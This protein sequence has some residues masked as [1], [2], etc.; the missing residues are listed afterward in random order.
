MSRRRERGPQH[1]TVSLG[2]RVRTYPRRFGLDKLQALSVHVCAPAVAPPAPV[3]DEAS[4]TGAP[5]IRAASLEVAHPR[6]LFEVP[7][8]VQVTGLLPALFPLP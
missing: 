1:S 4:Q 8:V 5:A 7:I 2:V 6:T 3:Q